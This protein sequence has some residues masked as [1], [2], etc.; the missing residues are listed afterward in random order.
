MTDVFISYAQKAPRATIALAHRLEKLG[1]AVWWDKGLLAGQKFD[2]TIREKLGE[3]GA[4]IVIW[5]PEAAVSDY[6]KLEAGIGLFTDKL[7]TLRVSDVRVEDI[8]I[9]FQPMHT[10]DVDDIG[11]IV[12]ALEYK[13]VHPNRERTGKNLSTE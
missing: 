6:V 5:T 4:I 3:A 13:G 10:I 9:I 2:N 7:V 1:Y 8:P 12:S 11:G